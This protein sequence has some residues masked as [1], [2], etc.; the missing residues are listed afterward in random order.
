MT[1]KTDY[2][3]PKDEW[4]ALSLVFK[5]QADPAAQQRAIR[6]I[7]EI[8]GMVNGQSFIQGEPDTSAFNE[9]RRWVA[10]QIQNALTLPMDQIVKEKVNEHR[11]NS[12]DSSAL[13]EF[14][15]HARNARNAIKPG[16]RE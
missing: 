6:H 2:L 4:L 12:R 3:W 9:G 10:R 11:I 15:E 1:D 14:I 5:G 13:G 7:V 16:G 8:L